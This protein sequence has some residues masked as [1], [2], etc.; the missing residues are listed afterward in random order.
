MCYVYNLLF[1]IHKKI[2]GKVII[3]QWL[4]CIT[5]GFLVL[6]VYA[7]WLIEAKRHE[8]LLKRVPV[9]IHVNGI[10]GKSTI[11]RYI[12]ST[13]RHAGIRC[14]GKTTGSATCIIDQEGND[15]AVERNAPATI[16][17]QLDLIHRYLD[18]DTQVI[19]LECMALRP[20]YQAVAE[21][22]MIKSTCGVINNVRLD[23]QD[24]LG[25]T[26]AEIAQSLSNTLPTNA[27]CFTSENHSDV[28]NVLHK[29]ASIVN[30]EVCTIDESTVT[31]DE[32]K[33]LDPFT[34][35]A[36]VALVLAIAKYHGI[37]R[38]Q[39]LTAI[40][41]APPDPGAA[42]WH[43]FDWQ[44]NRCYWINLFS[45]NDTNSLKQNLSQFNDWLNEDADTYIFLNNRADRQ[46]RTEQFVKFISHELQYSGIVV[47]GDRL[48]LIKSLLESEGIA[49]NDLYTFNENEEN[50][51]EKLLTH[52]CK[53]SS[54]KLVTLFGLANIHTKAA[55]ILLTKLEL[56]GDSNAT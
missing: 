39:A 23:H 42:S 35:R 14:I 43:Q 16:L 45:V 33:A 28:I 29:N 41:N 44:E 13:F 32:M 10:R 17:E 40:C 48:S 18:E 8:R 24:V 52:L 49:Q 37:D 4:L 30:S 9:R 1:Y 51:V 7:S 27:P 47:A 11:V 5:S 53:H 22:R 31:D 36:N 20:E 15:I 56:K 55:D 34:F 25:D 12:L 38:Q 2:G 19:V 21:H 3:E 46:D 54:K 26:L 6:G 50:C